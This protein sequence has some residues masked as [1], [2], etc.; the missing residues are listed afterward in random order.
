MRNRR[1]SGLPMPL[2]E[3]LKPALDAKNGGRAREERLWAQIRARRG[4]GGH[5]EPPKAG[6]YLPAPLGRVLKSDDSMNERSRLWR[7]IRARQSARQNSKEKARNSWKWPAI[8][9]GFAT[10]I[11]AIGFVTGVLPPAPRTAEVAVVPNLTLSDGTAVRAV[12]ASSAPCVI[13]LADASEIR[14]DKGASVEPLLSSGSRFELLLRH[15]S[16]EFSVTPRG[17]RRWVIEAGF[18]TVEVVGTVFR[19]ERKADRVNVSVSRGTVLVRGEGVPD[20]VQRLTAGHSISVGRSAATAA[21]PAGE[22]IVTPTERSEAATVEVGA[23]TFGAAAPEATAEMVVTE[24]EVAAAAEQALPRRAPPGR[25]EA[26]WH[27]HLTRGE[28]DTAYTTLGQTG[29]LREVQRT[30]DPQR[31]LELADVARLSGHPVESVKPLDR[32]LS[33]HPESPHAGIA[34]FTLGRVYLDQLKQPAQ[35]AK[36]FEQA[37]TLHPPHALLA[38]CH[39]R[40]VEAYARA[41]DLD[42]AERAAS[43]YRTLF[44]A[45]RQLTDLSRWTGR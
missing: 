13:K 35:A 9:F 29:L 20:R 31:L 25:Q 39:V 32:L 6:Q 14:L 24:H 3:T 16:A 19:V 21:V 44:P 11:F 2:S 8:G 7:G 10:A 17:P 27:K 23:I 5:S 26:P 38:D 22:P 41:G 42:S 33:L 4:I 30:E 12:D 36:A 43:R 37:I 18:A 45:G 1:T 40:L 15:G 28:F 34:A